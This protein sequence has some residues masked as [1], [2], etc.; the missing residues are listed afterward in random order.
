MTRETGASALTSLP[1][2]AAA[3]SSRSGISVGDDSSASSNDGVTVNS[4]TPG[5]LYVPEDSSGEAIIGAAITPADDTTDE[6][7]IL[8]HVDGDSASPT[9]GNFGVGFSSDDIYLT[10]TDGNYNFRA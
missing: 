4:A 6:S 7:S 10:P 8:W 9:G 2:A 5:Q 1:R 3:P